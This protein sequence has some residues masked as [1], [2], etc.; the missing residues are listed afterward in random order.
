MASHTLL[1]NPRVCGP[2][3]PASVFG[4]ILVL[5]LHGSC[6]QYSVAVSKVLTLQTIT[7]VSFFYF[8]LRTLSEPF[9]PASSFPLSVSAPTN[10]I[11][12]RPLKLA[13]NVRAPPGH[14]SLTPDGSLKRPSNG[15]A[16]RHPSYPA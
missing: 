16:D 12:T 6:E 8:K 15:Q 3:R 14:S 7:N 11:T 1:L 13:S 2:A 5:L 4:L 10:S 9:S